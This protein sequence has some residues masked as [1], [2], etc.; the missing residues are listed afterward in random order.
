MSELERFLNPIFNKTKNNTLITINKINLST[1]FK[2][3]K[4][5]IRIEELKSPNM[6]FTI[7]DKKWGFHISGTGNQGSCDY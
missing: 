2:Y 3:L 1:L 6:I 7:A 4:S 5:N